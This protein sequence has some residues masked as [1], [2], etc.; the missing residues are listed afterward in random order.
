MS[1]LSVPVS[2]PRLSGRAL[3]QYRSTVAIRNIWN[4]GLLYMVTPP[5]TKMNGL[6]PHMMTSGGKYVGAAVL[7]R[8]SCHSARFVLQAGWPGSLYLANGLLEIGHGESVVALRMTSSRRHSTS[9]APSVVF[10][11]NTLLSCL[12]RGSLLYSYRRRSMM[13]A[14]SNIAAPFFA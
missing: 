6:S 14:V 11:P 2:H 8:T 12:A 10:S 7:A 1:I 9:L 5:S 4:A 3:T 13:L